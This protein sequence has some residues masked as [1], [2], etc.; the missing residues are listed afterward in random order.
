MIKGACSAFH[1][2][3][4]EMFTII[5]IIKQNKNVAVYADICLLGARSVLKFVSFARRP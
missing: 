1:V 5:N 2:D 3:T 4:A